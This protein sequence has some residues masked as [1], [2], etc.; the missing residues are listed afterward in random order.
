MTKSIDNRTKLILAKL[1]IQSL[2]SLFEGNE[3]ESYLYSRLV[4][5]KCE[6]NR[7]LSHYK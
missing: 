1:Q 6:V 7:Q 4:S 5:I 3:Y 2:S